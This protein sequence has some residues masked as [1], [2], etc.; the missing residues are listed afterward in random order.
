MRLVRVLLAALLLS[1]CA[2]FDGRGLEPG[3]ATEAQVRALMGPT[4]LELKRPNGDTWL[5]FARHPLGR[6]T[7]VATIGPDGVLRGIE[8]RLTYWNVHAV[9]EGMRMEEVRQLL[10][11]PREVSHFER[12]K[13]EVWEYAWRDGPRAR[14]LWVQFSDDGVAREVIETNDREADPGATDARN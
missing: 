12:Q 2:S 4:A 5:Y 13:R 3:K 10:G 14:I 7:F 1:G 8:Q 11:P 9:K 6:A